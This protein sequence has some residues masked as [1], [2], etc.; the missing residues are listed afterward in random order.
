MNL[1]QMLAQTAA[2]TPDKTAIIFHDQRTS[3][4]DFDERANQVAH[5]LI[6]LG[7]QPGDRVALYIHNLPIFMEAYFG[8]LRAGASVVPLNVLY[9]AGEVEYILRDSGAKAILSFGP[10]AQVAL[11]AAANCPALQ[12]V[13]VAAPQDIPGTLAWRAVFGEA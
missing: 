7:V 13:I 1:G 12:H 6:Q 9:K 11:A 5:G 2:Q 8:I 3:Y 4:R 10:F